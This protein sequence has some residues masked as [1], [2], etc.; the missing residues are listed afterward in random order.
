MQVCVLEGG[1]GILF[2]SPRAWIRLS[3]PPHHGDPIPLAFVV[4]EPLKNYRSP[5]WKTYDGC[6]GLLQCRLSKCNSRQ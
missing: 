5:I 4:G 1:S 3:P 2:K 6:I